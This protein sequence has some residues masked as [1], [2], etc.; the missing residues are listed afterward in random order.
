MDSIL[1]INE[2]RRAKSQTRGLKNSS[3][4]SFQATSITYNFPFSLFKKLLHVDYLLQNF[5]KP[6]F[7]STWKS[8][9][10]NEAIANIGVSFQ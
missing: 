7:L 5:V 10:F 9:K 2:E 1:Q 3:T 6:L 8:S 4:R